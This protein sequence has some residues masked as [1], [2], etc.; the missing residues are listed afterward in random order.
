VQVQARAAL[1]QLHLQAAQFRLRVAQ[2]VTAV[3]LLVLRAQLQV[4]PM[5]GKARHSTAYTQ[6]P[7][8]ILLALLRVLTVRKLSQVQQLHPPQVSPSQLAQ[9]AQQAQTVQQA[10]A[11]T[12][13]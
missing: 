5:A 8:F 7:R 10:A 12:Y 9:A 13:G 4:Q 6:V 3:R 2:Q 11:A 1:R